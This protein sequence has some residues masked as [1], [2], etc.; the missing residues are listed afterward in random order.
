VGAP[1]I[2]CEIQTTHVW[3]SHLSR[4]LRRSGHEVVVYEEVGPVGAMVIDWEQVQGEVIEVPL[5]DT[6]FGIMLP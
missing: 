6:Q 5:L 1:E 2:P 3:I 4:Y